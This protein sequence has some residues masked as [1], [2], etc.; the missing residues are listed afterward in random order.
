MTGTLLISLDCEGKWGF[1]DVPAILDDDTICDDSLRDAYDFLFRS[2]EAYELRATFAVVGLFVAGRDRTE[3]HIRSVT[4]EPAHRRWLAVPRMALAS[5]RTEGWFFE[6]LPA[7]VLA[8]DRHELASHGFSHLPFD[9]PGVDQ[10][11][12]RRELQSMQHAS[13]ASGW[14]IESMVYPRNAVAHSEL[15]REYGIRRHRSSIEP[16]T[17][18]ERLRSLV[19]EFN[20][21]AASD[22]AAGTDDRVSPGRLVNWRSGPRR[23]VPSSVTLRRWRGIMSHAASSGGCAHLWFHPHNLV[24]GHRQRELVGAILASAGEFVRRGELRS[25]TFREV[26]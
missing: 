5:G 6:D 19:G 18:P 25:I 23:I 2:F 16:V 10:P 24:T 17:L 22:S 3:Q 21:R 20:V 9:F 26:A 1:A 7:K 14:G 11:I 8:S 13:N 4:D 12:V 15:L